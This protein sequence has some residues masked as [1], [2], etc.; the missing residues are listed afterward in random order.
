MHAT[1]KQRE[2]GIELGRL[3]GML[4]IGVSAGAYLVRQPVRDAC[5]TSGLTGRSAACAALQ[6]FTH[7]AVTIPLVLGGA[8]FIAANAAHAYS[9]G[10]IG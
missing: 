8:A 7:D 3:V 2:I 10:I 9:E 6:T 1:D 5:T 4:L